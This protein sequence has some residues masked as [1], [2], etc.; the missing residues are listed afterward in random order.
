MERNLH[1]LDNQVTKL[2]SGDLRV[3]KRKDGKVKFNPNR[4]PNSL[5]AGGNRSGESRVSSADNSEEEKRQL[6]EQCFDKSNISLGRMTK[7]IDKLNSQKIKNI[8]DLEKLL[9]RAQLDRSQ[10]INEKFHC[11]WKKHE[12]SRNNQEMREERLRSTMRILGKSPTNERCQKRRANSN[13][14]GSESMTKN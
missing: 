3:A 4:D 13:L 7:T 12:E 11:I 8:N 5:E 1:T 6:F 2:T 14:P 10:M 9:L